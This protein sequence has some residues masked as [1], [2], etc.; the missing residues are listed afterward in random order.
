MSN[1]KEIRLLE[2]RMQEKSLEIKSY[3][4]ARLP[5]VGLVAQYNLLAKYNFQDFF[6]QVP[7]E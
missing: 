3:K 6:P 1:S 2:S 4:A 7:A 5:Q